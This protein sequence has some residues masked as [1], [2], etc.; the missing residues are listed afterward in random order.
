VAALLQRQ[1]A[2]QCEAHGG[3]IVKTMGDAVLLAFDDAARAGNAL[4]GLHR[5]YPTAARALGLEALPVHSGAHFGE[6]TIT[7][8][9]DVFGQTVNIAARLQGLA[10]PGQAVV[11]EAF[12][13]AAGAAPHRSLGP[14][15]LKNVPEP[16]V[17][18]ELSL[19]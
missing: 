13:R 5:E 15:V 6:V 19:A 12:A 16:V 10:S 2:M 17:C 18:E 3:R 7:G 11:S 1:A 9:G 14:R 4:A 8:D